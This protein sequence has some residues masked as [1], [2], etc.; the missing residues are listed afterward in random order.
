MSHAWVVPFKLVHLGPTIPIEA[1]LLEG[2][3]LISCEKGGRA[4]RDILHRRDA[5]IAPHLGRRSVCAVV[6][7]VW[8]D[9]ADIYSR[10]DTG[11]L[12]E[13]P[14]CSRRHTSRE[15]AKL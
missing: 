2:A 10:D 12:E 4:K 3:C 8:G 14:E 15:P 6:S 11:V 9:G 1:L 13:G 7:V 5:D